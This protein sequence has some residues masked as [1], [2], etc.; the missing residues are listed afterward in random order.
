MLQSVKLIPVPVMERA[1]AREAAAPVLLQQIS[2]P[3][4]GVVFVVRPQN[5]CVSLLL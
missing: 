1:E 3:A 4:A 5:V 2:Y